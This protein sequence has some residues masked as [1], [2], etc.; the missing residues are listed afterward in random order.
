MDVLDEENPQPDD[1]EFKAVDRIMKE[2]IMVEESKVRTGIISKE[3][4]ERK[5]PRMVYKSGLSYGMQ[6]STTRKHV[7]YSR[8]TINSNFR[9][10]RLGE[11]LFIYES[12]TDITDGK[13]KY[14]CIQQYLAVLHCDISSNDLESLPAVNLFSNLIKLVANDSKLKD[15][16]NLKGLNNL[17]EIDFSRNDIEIIPETLC[18][19]PSL[20]TL[21]L[22]V[23]KIRAIPSFISNLTELEVLNLRYN[24]LTD[25]SN[26]KHLGGLLKLIDLR[27]SYNHFTFVPKE[28]EQLKN[29][30][31]LCLANWNLRRIHSRVF[32]LQLTGTRITA[33]DTG[34][35]KYYRCVEPLQAC[36]LYKPL[37][38]Y[39]MGKGKYGVRG[40]TKEI[41]NKLINHE[42]VYILLLCYKHGKA[43]H[44]F[45]YYAGKG[46]VLKICEQVLRL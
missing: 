44:S 8:D 43:D 4:I 45:L 20:Q 36:N 40:N 31:D 11:K 39:Y 25:N 21:N 28:L 32:G 34:S 19:L 3:K 38:D 33:I 27:L 22:T 14:R 16:S 12:Y 9:K 18:N 2:R 5:R 23:N 10:M 30:K 1:D 42:T 41:Y 15:V 29:L 24:K 17:R 6:I 37:Y 46:I 13:I 7:T 26:I 35:I